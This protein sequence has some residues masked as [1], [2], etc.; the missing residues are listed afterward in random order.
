MFVWSAVNILKNLFL[1]SFERII[2]WLSII[3]KGTDVDSWTIDELV[4]VVEEFK[5][6]YIEP[7]YN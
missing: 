2:Y 1:S 7:A 5:A 6:N 4:N 3:D